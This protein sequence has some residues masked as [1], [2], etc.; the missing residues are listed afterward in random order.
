M[1]NSC[2]SHKCIQCCVDTNMILSNNDI[3]R[4]EKLG[5]GKDF[6]IIKRNGWLQLR[7][8]NGRC[9][10]HNGTF[11]SIYVHRPEGC[12]LYPI[13]YDKDKKCEIFDEECLYRDEFKISKHKKR[14]LFTLIKKLENEKYALEDKNDI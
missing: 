9:V 5:F 8:K 3:N 14:R 2:I 1:A 13:T 6:F 10:F 11:C 12:R 7:N 4:I